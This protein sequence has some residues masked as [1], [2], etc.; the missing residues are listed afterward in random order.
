M[1]HNDIDD[2]K[3]RVENLKSRIGKEILSENEKVKPIT[4]GIINVE[5]YFN[6]KYKIL[7]ILKEPYDDFDDEGNPVGGDWGLDEELNKKVVFSEFIGG[8]RTYLPMIYTSYGILNDFIS[9]GGMEN[10]YKKPSMIDALKSVAY[11]N[12]KKL[13]GFTTSVRSVIEDA[14]RVNKDILNQQIRDYAPDIIIGGSTLYL[15]F[16]ELGL[17]NDDFQTLGSVEYAIKNNRIYI[18]A[19]HPSNRIV[20]EEMYCDD[21]INVVKLWAEQKG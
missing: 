6:S 5:K 20:K 13:P 1:E 12:V 4:D 11:I 17:S 2:L 16:N 7:W 10:V 3:N 21:I 15:F 19:Y 9:W 8:R 18:C 14:Y